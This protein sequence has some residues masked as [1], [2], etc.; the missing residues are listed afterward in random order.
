MSLVRS[1]CL[2]FVTSSLFKVLVNPLRVCRRYACRCVCGGM[3]VC[4]YAYTYMHL[5]EKK[6]LSGQVMGLAF[7]MLAKTHVFH[8]G[9][10]EF[11]T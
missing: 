4:S 10:P 1:S 9:V 2:S 3:G 6:C 11:D 5:S 7:K 8:I